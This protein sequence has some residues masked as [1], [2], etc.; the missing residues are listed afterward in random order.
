MVCVTFYE[1]P[2][3]RNNARQQDVLRRAGHQLEVRNLLDE[4]WTAERLRSFFGQRPV[5]EWFNRS[6]PA[7]QAGH[8]V[9]E[10][11]DE[12]KALELM[13]LDP[14]LIRRPLLEAEGRRTAGFDLAAIDAWIGLQPEDRTAVPEICTRSRRQSPCR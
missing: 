7:I 12:A 4:S 3:C 5:S 11:L 6:A 14:L 13:L 10:A 8:V 2:G 1:I 9:P